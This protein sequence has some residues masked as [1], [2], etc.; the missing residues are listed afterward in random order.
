MG[1]VT[2]EGAQ[3]ELSEIIDSLAPGEEL[4]ITRNSRSVAK[5]V[6]QPRPAR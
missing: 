1:T 3:A 5:L 2:I 4:I 6:G